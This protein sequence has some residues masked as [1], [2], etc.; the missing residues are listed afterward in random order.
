[1]QLARIYRANN[2]PDETI[3]KIHSIL[4]SLKP[5][6]NN[7]ASLSVAL[8]A[9]EELFRQEIKK[10][11]LRGFDCY[12]DLLIDIIVNSIIFEYEH[13]YAFLATISGDW[14]FHHPEKFEKLFRIIPLP[15][16]KKVNNNR[17]LIN[18]GQMLNKKANSLQGSN[19]IEQIAEYATLSTKYYQEVK[20]LNSFHR[21]FL[22]ESYHMMG[23][24]DTAQIILKECFDILN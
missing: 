16:P 11:Y 20:E 19:S 7:P 23:D 15:N 1:M 17:I 18:L 13:S 21:R 8:A 3:K 5:D 24:S 22:A 9:Y 14:S 6:A 2:R 12:I 10:L 4:S